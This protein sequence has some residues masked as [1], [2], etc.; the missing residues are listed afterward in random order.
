MGLGK[1]I[2]TLSLLAIEKCNGEKAPTLIVCPRT[3]TTHWTKE[4][5]NYFPKEKTMLKFGN[6][7]VQPSKLANTDEIIVVSYEELRSNVKKFK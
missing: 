2:Q 4:W 7:N 5:K 1:T 6:D 3:L